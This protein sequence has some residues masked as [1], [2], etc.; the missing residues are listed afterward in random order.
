[1]VLTDGTDERCLRPLVASAL[2]KTHLLPY[3]QCVEI[4]LCNAVT[5]KVNFPAIGSSDKTVILLRPQC[6]YA[7][8]RR[9]R[10]CFHMPLTLT[11]EVLEL[12]P[13][14]LEGIPYGDTNVL[15]RAG[16]GGFAAY[17][18]I[19]APGNREVQSNRIDVTPMVTVLR[20]CDYRT[21]GDDAIVE[22]LELI[23]LFSDTCFNTLGRGVMLENH[24]NRNVHDKSLGKDLGLR[25]GHQK[26]PF[27]TF[28]LDWKANKIGK[29]QP[30]PFLMKR[31]G[32]ALTKIM[33]LEIER[34]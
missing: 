24:L 17:R 16:G 22:L 29:L 10:V 19:R 4:C 27:V 30:K 20:P 31:S 11:G 33:L 6:R 2:C 12:S 34:S 3:M 7:A 13:S 25:L 18:N 8:M 32:R 15:V 23:E 26:Q 21:R 1:M 9:R 28:L 5:V 14:R